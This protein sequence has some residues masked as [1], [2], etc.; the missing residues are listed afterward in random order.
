MK[1]LDSEMLPIESKSDLVF[2]RKR[3]SERAQ[4]LEMGLTKETEL[5]TAVTELLTNIMRYAERGTAKIEILEHL[6][7]KGLRVICQDEGPGIIDVKAALSKGFSTGKSLG[8][9]LFGCKNLVD[10]FD[11]QSE[12][13]KGTRVVITKW[14]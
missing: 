5:K 11:L 8:H 12:P 9:G 2:I 13:G 3:L 10:S 4:S 14:C 1:V 7:H 6:N